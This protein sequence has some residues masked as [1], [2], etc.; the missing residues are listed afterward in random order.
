[1][2]N[3]NPVSNK[4]LDGPWTF[5]TSKNEAQELP[6]LPPDASETLQN[7]SKMPQVPPKMPRRPLQDIQNASKSAQDGSKL[8]QDPPKTLPRPSPTRFLEVYASNLFDVDALIPS[9]NPKFQS[10]H[11]D[12]TMSINCPPRMT[13]V[14]A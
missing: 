9:L 12:L 3:F 13:V 2:L 8:P 7:P 6:K 1:M 14:S 5:K 10:Q 11:V 4:L